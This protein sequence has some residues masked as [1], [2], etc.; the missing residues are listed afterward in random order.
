MEPSSFNLLVKEHNFKTCCH[1]ALVKTLKSR[2]FQV[3]I[4]LLQKTHKSPSHPQL[5]ILYRAMYYIWMLGISSGKQ[6][7]LHHSSLG[8]LLQ[9]SFHVE[10]QV[11]WPVS[12]WIQFITLPSPDLLDIVNFVVSVYCKSVYLVIWIWI[13]WLLEFLFW[14]HIKR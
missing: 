14:I 3:L 11:Y 4:W 8:F 6:N 5:A 7:I 9:I 13:N 2:W 12:E 10:L 1:N